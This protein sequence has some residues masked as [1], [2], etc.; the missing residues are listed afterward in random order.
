MTINTDKALVSWLQA[1]RDSAGSR[2]DECLRLY[3]SLQQGSMATKENLSLL[4]ELLAT[5]SVLS[6]DPHTV[7]CAMLF[8]ATECGQ[9]PESISAEI[10]PKV[11]DQLNQLLYLI[12]LE[13]EHL[14]A[15][16]SHSAEGLRSFALERVRE[17]SL[18]D[19]EAL[20]VDASELAGH[21]DQSY[22]IFS[23]PARHVAELQFSPEMSRWVAEEQWHPDQQGSLDVD[24]VWTLKIPFS[25]PRELIMDILRYGAEVEVLSPGFLRESVANSAVETASIYS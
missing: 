15:S 5:M 19:A 1:Y 17:Q 10:S 21:F 7:S 23:G 8:V 25:D 12:E 6:P 11:K 4:Q 3:D 18:L 22:G 2:A 20:D 9:D 14:P 16:T 13:T 24:G